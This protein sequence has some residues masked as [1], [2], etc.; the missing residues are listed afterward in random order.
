HTNLVTAACQL[1]HNICVGH[2]NDLTA[3]RSDPSSLATCMSSSNRLADLLLAGVGAVLDQPSHGPELRA[4]VVALAGRLLPLCSSQR[5]G[6]C[7][8]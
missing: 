3:A 8:F 4:V 1:L 2:L 7:L 5:V 6:G